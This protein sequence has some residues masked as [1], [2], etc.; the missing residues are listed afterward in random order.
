LKTVSA[1]KKKLRLQNV[2]SNDLYGVISPEFEDILIQYG[3]GRDTT[4]GDALN[5]NGFIM[6]FYG[7]KL[8]SSNQ[9]AGSAVLSLVTQPTN[10]DTITIEGVTFT[11]VSSIGTT[12]G[13]V[14]IETNVD[15]TRGYLT[16]LINNPTV[17]S[18]KRVALAAA[19]ARA[20]AATVSAV[21]SNSADTLTVKYKGVGTITVA[22]ALTDG[23]DTR[24][25][26][27]IKQHCLFGAVGN[28]VLVMQRSP[29]V[30]IK[31]VPDKLGKNVLNG[32][33]YGVKTFADN[34]KA[35]VNVK[36]NASGF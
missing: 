2:S 26:T 4:M 15:T 8:Y 30:Q 6:K 31:E 12:P 11:F 23:T 14:L 36:L 5:E 24:T 18:A 16:D 25:A 20:F 21:N 17:T 35:L 9:L 7:F 33:L 27:K 13:N 28:P 1:A 32:V 10:N 19:D 34:A 22:E 29:S 3:A